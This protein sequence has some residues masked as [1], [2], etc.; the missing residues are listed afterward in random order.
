LPFP[1]SVGTEIMA[2]KLLY[3]LYDVSTSGTKIMSSKMF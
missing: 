2:G 3:V 1:S